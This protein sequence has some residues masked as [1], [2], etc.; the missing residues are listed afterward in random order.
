MGRLKA[1]ETRSKPKSHN[2]YLKIGK[3]K[4]FS[5]IFFNLGFGKILA[6]EKLRQHD[7]CT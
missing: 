2:L 5:F 4:K 1:T 6:A 7:G 3:K